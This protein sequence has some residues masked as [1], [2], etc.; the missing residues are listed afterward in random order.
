M[1]LATRTDG[2]RD[3]TL[4]VVSTDAQHCLP[5]GMTLQTALDDWARTE[6][7]LR[8]LSERLAAGQ[9][10][11]LDAATLLAPLPRAWQWLDGSAF[12][13]HGELMQQAFKLPPIETDKPLMYQG[14]SHRFLS[15]REDVPLPSEADGI[16]FRGRVRGRER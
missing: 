12:P 1:R 15:G 4:V 16:E 6:P 8:A 3:G 5:A 7:V 14:M 13:T 2:S 9:G 10:E 11:P